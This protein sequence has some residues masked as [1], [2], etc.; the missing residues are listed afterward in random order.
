MVFAGK[1]PVYCGYYNMPQ[2]NRK[3]TVLSEY[4]QF[5]RPS[6]RLTACVPHKLYLEACS[7]ISLKGCAPLCSEGKTLRRLFKVLRFLIPWYYIEF[8][9]SDSYLPNDVAPE[10]IIH[11]RT[12]NSLKRDKYDIL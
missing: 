5:N 2:F 9:V 10:N 12:A 6:S 7:I 1:F 8:V 4:S 11:S 3:S